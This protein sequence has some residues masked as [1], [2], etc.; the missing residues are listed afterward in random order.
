MKSL[1]TSGVVL[2]LFLLW[3]TGIFKERLSLNALSFY[4]Q[5][6]RT[7]SS[8]LFVC[9]CVCFLKK[10]FQFFNLIINF[11]L[12]SLASPINTEGD[13]HALSPNN[14]PGGAPATAITDSESSS[15]DDDDAVQDTKKQVIFS[16]SHSTPNPYID[17]TAQNAGSDANLPPP[18][19]N[20]RYSGK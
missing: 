15:S 17:S 20:A 1:L 2:I 4:C 10:V 5:I 7:K 8:L 16:G 11:Y 19:S 13:N 18:S 6:S 14:V 3:S 9:L 12:V